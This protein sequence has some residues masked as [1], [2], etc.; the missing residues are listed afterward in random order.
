M[1]DIVVNVDILP[2]VAPSSELQEQ[3]L[4][5]SA[6]NTESTASDS[7]TDERLN[8]PTKV[9]DRYPRRDCKVT[10][11]LLCEYYCKSGGNVMYFVVP[12]TVCTYNLYSVPEV[13]S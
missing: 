12:C 3:I 7:V 13:C 8:S 6:V 11:R 5:D 9:V 10:E 2:I 1:P 4:T